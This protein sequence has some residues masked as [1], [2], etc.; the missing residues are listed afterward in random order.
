MSDH[1]K[2]LPF[3]TTMIEKHGRDV[4]FQELSNV[5][6]DSDKP[7]NGTNLIPIDLLTTKACFVPFRGFELGSNF[8]DE[9]LLKRCDQ[10]LLVAPT[11][12]LDNTSL[13]VDNGVQYKV[14]WIRRLKPAEVILLYAFGVTR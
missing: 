12:N 3:V 2:F 11:V 13:I 8:I 14:D 9:E 5:P 10:V 6:A 7:W 1:V 4:V